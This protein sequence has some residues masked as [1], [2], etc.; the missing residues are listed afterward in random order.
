MI[1]FLMALENPTAVENGAFQRPSDKG[2]RAIRVVK[3]ALR[4]YPP[5]RRV[6][7]MFDDE[8]VAANIEKREPFTILAGLD[9]LIF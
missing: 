2:V 7:R 4:L 6:H 1:D 5:T 3:K 8:I 9:P